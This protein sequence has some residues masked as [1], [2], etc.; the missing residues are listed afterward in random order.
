[1]L[2]LG[3]T[4]GVFFTCMASTHP[5]LPHLPHHPPPPPMPQNCTHIIMSTQH[6]TNL[7]E[8]VCIVDHSHL[9][10]PFNPTPLLTLPPL[11]HLHLPFLPRALPS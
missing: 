6:T 4:L 7:A 5:T 8:H 2:W 10:T 11:P 9:H 3:H 1:M